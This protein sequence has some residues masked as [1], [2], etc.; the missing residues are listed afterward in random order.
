MDNGSISLER[1]SGWGAMQRDPEKANYI[2]VRLNRRSLDD[3]QIS[4]NGTVVV[5]YLEEFDHRDT[6]HFHLW[7]RHWQLPLGW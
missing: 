5:V 7:R 4:T 6:P 2:D 1:P 3:D